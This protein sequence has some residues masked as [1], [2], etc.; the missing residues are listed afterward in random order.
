MGQEAILQAGEELEQMP[1]SRE[2]QRG[3]LDAV[4]AHQHNRAPAVHCRDNS[5][6]FMDLLNLLLQFLWENHCEENVQMDYPL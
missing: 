5:I 1:P 3:S 2:A 6:P 4:L